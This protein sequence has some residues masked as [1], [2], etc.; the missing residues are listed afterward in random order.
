M[1]RIKPGDTFARMARQLDV[2]LILVCATVTPPAGLRSPAPQV[3]PWTVYKPT[4]LRIASD[5]FTAAFNTHP[6]NSISA[7]TPLALY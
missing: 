1:I 4:G 3:S 5:F 7:V 2:M 6:C